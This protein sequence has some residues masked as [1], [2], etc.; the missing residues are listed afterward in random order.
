MVARARTHTP[1]ALAPTG[2]KRTW[3]RLMGGAKEVI[4]AG[5]GDSSIFADDGVP[6]QIKCG[7]GH[8]GVI[9]DRSVDSVS[10]DCENVSY[11]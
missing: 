3:M 11:A 8:D 1:A 7:E 10:A 9:A 5:A 4:N 6:D 2:S